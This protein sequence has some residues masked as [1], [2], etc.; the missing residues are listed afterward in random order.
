MCPE[1]ILG[2]GAGWRHV[3][4]LT[5]MANSQFQMR[6]REVNIWNLG[7]LDSTNYAHQDFQSDFGCASFEI[8]DVLSTLKAAYSPEVRR[9]CGL[10]P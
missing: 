8:S 9:A 2:S 6:V 5:P 10:F 1:E 3:P 4:P 7:T